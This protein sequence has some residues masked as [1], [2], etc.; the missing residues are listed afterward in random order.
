MKWEKRANF[1][2]Q[3]LT[4]EFI[5]HQETMMILYATP[6][7]ADRVL[8]ALN[9][10]LPATKL[11]ADIVGNSRGYLRVHSNAARDFCTFCHGESPSH[12]EAV[13]HA[14]KCPIALAQRLLV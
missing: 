5:N 10:D 13:V 12:A 2:G 6:E 4:W 7:Q 3:E 1:D 9:E 11:L 8:A 14:E